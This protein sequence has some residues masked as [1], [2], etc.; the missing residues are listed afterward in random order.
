MDKAFLRVLVQEMTR[1]CIMPLADN[2]LRPE[3]EARDTIFFVGGGADWLEIERQVE[4]LGFGEVYV[5]SFAKARRTNICT[6]CVRPVALM[7]V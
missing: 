4:R 3:L 6:V 2:E 5:V 1:T 7:A